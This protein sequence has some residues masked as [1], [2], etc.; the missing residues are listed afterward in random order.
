LG[1]NAKRLAQGIGELVGV[2][3]NGLAGDLVG[4]AS[5]VADGVD[6]FDNVAAFGIAI[7]LA[8]AKSVQL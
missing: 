8:C 5:I 4:P 7:N 2:G 1:N 3:G 6:N